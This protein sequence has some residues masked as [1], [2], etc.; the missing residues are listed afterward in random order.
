MV[1]GEEKTWE[2]VQHWL[3]MVS[4]YLEDHLEVFAVLGA[5]DLHVQVEVEAVVHVAGI[6]I[7]HEDRRG[8]RTTA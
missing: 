8:E 1:Q 2:P 4:A 3:I 7:F 6:I 5:E